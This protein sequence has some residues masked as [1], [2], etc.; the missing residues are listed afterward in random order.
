MKWPSELADGLIDPK[1]IKDFTTLDGDDGVSLFF[2]LLDSFLETYD[3]TSQELKFSLNKKE[4]AKV[5]RLAHYLKSGAAVIGAIDTVELCRNLEQI[6]W[7]GAAAQAKA[8]G[9]SEKLSLQI[10]R[11]R[12]LQVATSPN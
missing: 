7:L 9:L 5:R 8:L 3:K 2:E 10:L 4:A 12:Q 1:V 11:L 6:D